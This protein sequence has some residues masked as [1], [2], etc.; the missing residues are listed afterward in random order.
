MKNFILNTILFLSI[1]C[2]IGLFFFVAYRAYLPAPKISNSYSLNEKVKFLPQGQNKDILAIGS[3]MSLNNISSE[4]LSKNFQT[5]HY[6][7]TGAWGLTIQNMEEL[8]EIFNELYNPKI[9]VC[10]SNIMDF[11]EAEIVYDINELRKHL[12]RQRKA[13]IINLLFDRYYYQHA[14]ENYTN[15]NRTDI[16]SSLQFDPYGGV[17]LKDQDFQVSESRWNSSLP[18]EEVSPESYIHLENISKNLRHRDQTF[19]FVQTPV[20]KIMHTDDY[21]ANMCKHTERIALILKKYDH[22]FLDL[23]NMELPDEYFADLAHLKNKGSKKM[24][25]LIYTA[26]H[27]D[28]QLLQN[29]SIRTKLTSKN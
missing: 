16:V 12:G 4:E 28:Q 7:N 24:T 6:I 13:S 1:P 27:N 5:E 18:F 22:V 26:F 3:S 21:K 23:S 8:V 19:I 2:A 10:A 14:L 20:R 17:P 15:F 9:V 25:K 29:F 11:A